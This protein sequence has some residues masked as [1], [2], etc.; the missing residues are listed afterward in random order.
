MAD[1]AFGAQTVDENESNAVAPV[2]ASRAERLDWIGGVVR[3]K[4]YSNGWRSVRVAAWA[5]PYG[6]LL[7]AAIVEG[8]GPTVLRE[9]FDE[10]MEQ[11][12]RHERPTRLIVWP[13]AERPFR[14]FEYPEVVVHADPFLKLLVEDA[15]DFGT[16]PGSLDVRTGSR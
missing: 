5:R 2:R 6:E 11:A 14:A 3:V 15:A 1:S 8:H 4:I 12:G 7:A 10:A 16:I 13:S 9:L